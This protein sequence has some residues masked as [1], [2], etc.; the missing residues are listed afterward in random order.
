[1]VTTHPLERNLRLAYLLRG[2]SYT[3]FYIPISVPFY[4]SYGLSFQ[5]I[6]WLKAVLSLVGLILE[7]PTGYFA[8]R[9]GRK[10]SIVVGALLW[11]CSVF[12]YCS[13]ASFEAF[14]VAEVLLGFGMSF[15]AGADTALI[16][17][18]LRALGREHEYRA[19]EGRLGMVAGFTEALCGL[20]GGALAVMSL[21]YPFYAQFVSI[22]LLTVLSFALYEAPQQI[23]Q[24]SELSGI[25]SVAKLTLA[26]PALRALILFSAI[27]AAASL[28]MVWCA[29]S[30][31]ELTRIPLQYFGM[32]WALFHV[33]LALSSRVAST[34]S[35]FENPKGLWLVVGITAVGLVGLGLVTSPWG[36]GF[37]VLLYMTR[38]IRAP[39][40]KSMLNR[41]IASEHRATVLSISNFVFRL[42]FCALGPLI[43][44]MTDRVGLQ[45]ALLVVAVIVTVPCAYLLREFLRHPH[46]T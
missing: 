3:W 7:I 33:V 8:D 34:S 37:I 10:I 39:V 42:T 44:V 14:L 27:G 13:G 32:V 45:N 12:L 1:M 35:F 41:R 21:R 40:I 11:V 23:R 4:Q 38:G 26:N 9:V 22:S 6:M 2:C 46:K 18:T 36:I 29:Q 24:A 19:L 5:Q 30:Y 15:I 16:F 43:G 28:S 20:I 25:R 17:D 31:M